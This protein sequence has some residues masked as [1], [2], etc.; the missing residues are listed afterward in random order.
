TGCAGV[1]DAQPLFPRRAVGE[2]EERQLPLIPGLSRRQAANRCA[3]RA[4]AFAAS[5]SRSLG[6]A[7]VRSWASSADE[8][9]ATASTALL[10]AASF[11]REGLWKP[12]ILRT[13]C[14]AA[15]R[16]S[17]SVAGGSKL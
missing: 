3:A 2:L 12:L 10:N 5:T 13:Y 11:A 15:A 8:A 6:G 7:V 1:I 9:A 14:C 17:S 16:T 4:R